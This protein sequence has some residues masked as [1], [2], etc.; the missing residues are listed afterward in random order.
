MARS[1]PG[2]RAILLGIAQTYLLYRAQSTSLKQVRQSPFFKN[3]LRTPFARAVDP[4]VRRKGQ[5]MRTQKRFTPKVLDRY[6]RDGR[7]TGT[8]SN[9]IPWHRV[10]RSD[11][12]SLGRSHLIVWRN[13]QRELLSDG[14]STVFNFSSMLPNLAD[15]VEQFPLS[16]V[17][18]KFELS[19]WDIRVG[20]PVYPGTIALAKHLGIKHPTLKEFEEKRLWTST[21]D[22]LLVLCTSEEQFELLAVS[23][24]PGSIDDLSKRA[25]QLLTLEKEYWSA[26]GVT[27]LLITPTLYEKSVALT[28]RRTAPW[29][30]AEPV[31]EQEM[32]LACHTTVAM[33]SYPESDI[34]NQI[35]DL[36]HDRDDQYLAKR[37]LWQSIWQ[38]RL[39]VDLRR[40]WRPHVPFKLI[41]HKQFISMNPVLSRR[42][43]W[44]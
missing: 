8:F 18:S 25:R 42:S 35:S 29:G 17:D 23:V 32:A 9:Y 33:S 4:L 12:S 6:L 22:L 26:R 19:R 41:T 14:E 1:L 3:L 15:L 13:R 5:I 40:G 28:L 10:S 27:W 20:H 21:T 38:G 31:S 37:A 11:P 43:A 2:P 36:L 7:G 24:K 34:V 16:Q 44:I 39:P 30:L